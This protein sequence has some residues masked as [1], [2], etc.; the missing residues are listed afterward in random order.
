VDGGEAAVVWN[1]IFWT[2]T[3]PVGSDL[4][5]ETRTGETAVPDGSWSA[6]SAA[7]T[8]NEG[9]A[10]VSP[11]GRYIQY[12]A[13]FTGSQ[14][15]SPTLHDV[16]L[17]YG[18]PTG[19]DLHAVDKVTTNDVWAVGKAGVVI[20]W[21]GL[22]WILGVSPTTDD[23][24]G[25]DMFSAS[26]GIAVGENGRI[27]SWNGT[28]WSNATSPTAQT[29][30]DVALTAA[31]AGFAVG[32]NGTIIRDVAGTWSTFASPTANDLMGID[33]VSAS[34]CW[35]V[36]LGG[37]I[38][39]WNGTAWTSFGSPTLIDL[40]AIDMLSASDG[41]A[42][43]ASGELIRWNG[44]VWSTVVSPTA[45]DL[46]GV[47]IVSATDGWAVGDGG[48][49]IRWD[50]AAWA[51]ELTTVTD[52]LRDIVITSASPIDGWAVGL[53]GRIL[54]VSQGAGYAPIGTFVSMVLDTDAGPASWDAFFFTPTYAAG[55][56]AT[57]AFR[58]GD[59]AVPDGTWSVWSSE[60]SAVDGTLIEAPAA[61]YLQYRVTLTTSDT[62]ETP[63]IDDVM[64]TYHK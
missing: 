13:T 19:Q 40:Q 23:L 45:V 62:E 55:T 20:H 59:V 11:V 63:E 53:H 17:L 61:Q 3:L 16:T 30:N 32:E 44:T 21:D 10:I 46:Y 36:G 4:T 57:L 58:S 2:E 7:L 14:T 31:A 47:H 56:A 49:I 34:D 51:T 48:T 25:L 9:S 33:C 8:D 42:V 24:F 60:Y 39:R 27:I 64:V 38:V 50:G 29:L 37:V 1:V 35:A 5:F 6:W 43:G 52:G 18:R 26:A 54:N 41:W 22:D 15:A 12:R 28:V